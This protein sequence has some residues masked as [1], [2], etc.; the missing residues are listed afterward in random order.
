MERPSYAISKDSSTDGVVIARGS[1][2]LMESSG[3]RAG[4]SS[5]ILEDADVGTRVGNLVVGGVDGAFV[6][7]VEGLF[8]CVRE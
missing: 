1:V 7:D 2:F 4:E 6:G 8:D 3:T 5:G